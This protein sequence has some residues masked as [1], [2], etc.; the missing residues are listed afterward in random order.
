MGLRPEEAHHARHV[1]RLPDGSTVEVFDDTGATAT[2]VLICQGSDKASVRVESVN[3]ATREQLRVVVAAAVPKGDRA[4]WMV[5]KLSEIGT[6]E[7]IPLAAERSVVLPGGTAKRQRWERI[8][9]EAAKQSRRSGVMSIAPLTPLSDAIAHAAAEGGGF[10]LSADPAAGRLQVEPITRGASSRLT[11]FIGPEGGWSDAEI[12][13]FARAGMRGLRLT[14]T[15]L[16][17]E[18]AAIVAAAGIMLRLGK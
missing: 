1:L 8:S 9:V 6:A 5:E 16:R 2:G 11:L 7:F 14:E 12:A 17:V 4:D 18:T 3:V 13:M 15:I 10:F